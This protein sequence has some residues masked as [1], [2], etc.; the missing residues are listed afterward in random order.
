MKKPKIALQ[1]WSVNKD[2]QTNL[3]KTV[4][5]V[6]SMGYAG[7]ELAG[8]HGKTPKEWAS[9]L[10]AS[11]LKASGAHT[12]IDSMMPDTISK[13]LDDYETIGCESITVPAIWGKYTDTLDGYRRACAVMNHAADIAAARGISIGYHN[14]DFEFKLLENRVPYFLMLDCLTSSVMLEIDMGWAYRVGADGAA[15][16]SAHPGREQAVHIKAYDPECET[17]VV[18]KDKVPWN[19]VFEACESS[20]ATEWYVIEHERYADEPLVCV[21]QCIDNM[22]AMGK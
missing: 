6:A 8:L 5:A 13:T 17:T 3:E 18:G 12:V 9:M 15:I 20:G 7:V 11:G 2:C 4:E 1:L 10:A 14:H 22:R 21:K 19:K 16:V